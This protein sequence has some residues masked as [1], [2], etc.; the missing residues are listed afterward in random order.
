[1]V[2]KLITYNKNKLF[3]H[4]AITLLSFIFLFCFAV[5]FVTISVSAEEPSI[6]PSLFLPSSPIE[7]N[8]LNNPIDAVY[9]SDGRIATIEGNNVVIHLTDGNKQ[10]IS[11]NDLSPLKQIKLFDENSLLVSANAKLYKISLTTDSYSYEVLKDDRNIDIGVNYFDFNNDYLITAYSTYLRIYSLENDV[12]YINEIN[13]VDGNS[14]IALINNEIILNHSN[15]T[16]NEFRVSNLVS[17]NTLKTI[18]EIII[19]NHII[20]VSDIITDDNNFYFICGGKIYR[21]NNNDFSVTMLKVEDSDFNLGNI[22]SPVSLAFKGENLLITDPTIGAIQEFR[23]EGDKLVF[24]GFAVAS[25]KTAFNRIGSSATEVSVAN[26]SLAVLDDYKLT[27]IKDLSGNLYSQDNYFNLAHSEKPD[28]I[29]VGNGT[30]L[31]AKDN[32][33]EIYSLSGEKL[34]TPDFDGN[35]ITDVCYIDGY[36]YI[37]MPNTG[38]TNHSVVFRISEIDGTAENICVAEN[39][40]GAATLISVDI[41]GN[42]ILCKDGNI[43]TS[44]NGF[45]ERINNTQIAN[46]KKIQTDLNGNVFAF[47][48]NA[49]YY[50]AEGQVKNIPLSDTFN[51]F[52]LSFDS[53]RVYF[54]K[55]NDERIYS[56]DELLNLSIT[57]IT[58]PDSFKTSGESADKN[59]F[60]TFSLNDGAVSFVISTDN[61]DKFKYEKTGSGSVNEYILICET[62]YKTVEDLKINLSILLGYDELRKPI[63]LAVKSELISKITS[64]S[65]KEEKRYVATDVNVYYLPMITENDDFCIKDGDGILRLRAKTEINVLGEVEF[66]SEEYNGKFLYIGLKNSRGEEVYGYVPEKFTVKVLSEDIKGET[67]ISR[68]KSDNGNSFNKALIVIAL[69]ASVF[70]TSLFFI[71]RKKG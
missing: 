70:G 60:K 25:E 27:V 64:A 68:I 34:F 30:V 54:I 48:G 37:V 43:Y 1:M 41:Y 65:D 3:R 47:T 39:H 36:Y 14:P 2:N 44:A 33:T 7:T 24:T 8:S 63:Y 59:N 42:V 20:Q 71:L 9:F 58:V 49:V 51:S 16:T 50:I 17:F 4:A 18:T 19:E 57:D 23:V 31:L 35:N 62:E 67:E 5:A 61:T 56:T 38:N 55:E 6:T 32:K 11:E 69:A 12:T 10:T 22:D 29:S 46:I 40:F 26:N 52:A 13:G 66:N 21:G 45:S 28:F 53:K 15:A